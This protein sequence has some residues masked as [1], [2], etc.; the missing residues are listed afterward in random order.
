MTLK[1]S[2]HIVKKVQVSGVRKFVSL[3]REGTR[4]VW[5]NRPGAYFLDW[6]DDGQRRRELAG[7]TPGQA[8]RA[9]KRKQAEIAVALVLTHH[10]IRAPRSPPAANDQAFVDPEKVRPPPDGAIRQFLVY[11][12]AN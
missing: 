3:E 8:L 12:A 10:Q 11:V 2:D 5:D 1:R 6:H 7:H 4:N 9:R